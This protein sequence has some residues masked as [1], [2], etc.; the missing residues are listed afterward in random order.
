MPS[1]IIHPYSRVYS[2]CKSG[3]RGASS[4]QLPPAHG[5][6]ELGPRQAVRAER[7]GSV[8]DAD[9]VAGFKIIGAEKNVFLIRLLKEMRIEG[10]TGHLEQRQAQSVDRGDILPVQAQH[11]PEFFGGGVPHANVFF[12]RR[13]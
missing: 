12:A 3:G 5:Q 4:R 1:S 8:N 10:P 2:S 13:T 11:A 9:P 7:K 6:I